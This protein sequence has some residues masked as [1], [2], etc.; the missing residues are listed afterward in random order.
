MRRNT[1]FSLFKGTSGTLA[2]AGDVNDSKNIMHYTISGQSINNKKP[3]RYKEL[4][5][6]ITG[7]SAIDNSKP[8]QNQWNLINR[9]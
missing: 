1:N 9:Q 7:T 8:K 3:F 4:N 5:P 6:V 2:L